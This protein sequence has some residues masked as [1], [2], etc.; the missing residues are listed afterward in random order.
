MPLGNDEQI[1]WRGWLVDSVGNQCESFSEKLFTAIEQRGIPK[2][3]VE[4]G[5]VNMWWRKES[6]Y[7]DVK[8]TLDGKFTSTIHLQDYGTSLWIGR[9]FE[10]RTWDWNYYKRMAACAFIE[11]ID[12]CIVDTILSI[13]D[14]SALHNVR[15]FQCSTKK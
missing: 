15:D 4:H 3:E 14:E 6:L 8:S 12:R 13:V 7:I 9:A 11:T 2:C 1:Q 5:T 10:G